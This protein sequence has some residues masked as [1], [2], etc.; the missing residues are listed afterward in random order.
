MPDQIIISDLAQPE[1]TQMQLGAIAAMPAM[2]ITVEGVLQAAK[3]ATG[4]SDFG[5]DD[6]LQRLGIWVE[7]INAD[8][9]LNA[10]GRASLF[11]D[12]KALLQP[13]EA[14]K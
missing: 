12:C 6:F 5:A 1:L 8:T 11:G 2:D 9:P 3:A 10:F 7:A 14:G 4:L 13:V